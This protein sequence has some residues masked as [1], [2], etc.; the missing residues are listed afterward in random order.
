[1]RHPLSIVLLGIFRLLH[2]VKGLVVGIDDVLVLFDLLRVLLD[3]NIEV[4]GLVLVASKVLPKSADL[5][6]L[7]SDCLI[8][9]LELFSDPPVPLVA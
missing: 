8:E 2:L 4:L 5:V 7:I 3:L 6:L 9:R 1:M